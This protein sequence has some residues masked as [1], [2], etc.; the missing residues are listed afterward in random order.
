MAAGPNYSFLHVPGP[1]ENPFA[2]YNRCVSPPSSRSSSA[3]SRTSVS[4]CADCVD[5]QLEDDDTASLCEESPHP[6]SDNR[7]TPPE[8]QRSDDKRARPPRLCKRNRA[9]L[10]TCEE[11]LEGKLKNDPNFDFNAAV[12]P[13]FI[14]RNEQLKLVMM[15]RLAAFRETIVGGCEGGQDGAGVG[16]KADSPPFRP[17]PGLGLSISACLGKRASSK[18]A[19]T[20]QRSK[21]ANPAGSSPAMPVSPG[22]VRGPVKIPYELTRKIPLPCGPV[23]RRA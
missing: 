2:K 20:R 12:L 4:A 13:H 22:P 21:A 1:P 8:A 17:P 3:S 14:A 5:V 18:R 11:T 7:D 23:P 6:G 19:S 15:A 16:V 9:R 10:R